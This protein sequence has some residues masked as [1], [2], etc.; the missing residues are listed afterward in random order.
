MKKLWCEKNILN[1]SFQKWFIMVELGQKKSQ[2]IQPFC[3]K[4]NTK[5]GCQK[6]SVKLPKNGLSLNELSKIL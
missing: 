4:L 1:D 6:S 3:L 2:Q 5:I